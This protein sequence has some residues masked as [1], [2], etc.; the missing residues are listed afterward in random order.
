M[1]HSPRGPPRQLARRSPAAQSIIASIS[2]LFAAPRTGFVRMSGMV[3]DAPA[4]LGA[5]RKEMSLSIRWT[6]SSR[7]GKRAT[8]SWLP[9][10]TAAR[11]HASRGNETF[12]YKLGHIDHV[13]E[14]SYD[15]FQQLVHDQAHSF[16]SA[17]D[18]HHHVEQFISG[19]RP[20]SDEA[21]PIT[22]QPFSRQHIIASVAER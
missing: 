5:M 17:A 13:G 9:P 22:S 15:S 4:K 16:G 8:S 1:L 19:V 21:P 7:R 12:D 11:K 20:G 6:S 14:M 18:L 10:R 2:S 3:I